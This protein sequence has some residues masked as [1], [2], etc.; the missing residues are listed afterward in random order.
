M[1]SG[2]NWKVMAKEYGISFESDETF[3]QFIAMKVTQ[4]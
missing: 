1:G 2:E 3:L 4:H